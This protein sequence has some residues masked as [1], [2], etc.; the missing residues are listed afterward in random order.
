MAKTTKAKILITENVE[1]A[2]NG[3]DFIYTDVWV[4]MGEAKSAW[5]E[6]IKLMLP[7]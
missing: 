4:S 5:E 2:V 7:Y 6:R 1:E 3:V